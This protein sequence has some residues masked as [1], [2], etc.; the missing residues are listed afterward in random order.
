MKQTPEQ[1]QSKLLGALDHDYEVQDIPTVLEVVS[2]LEKTSI[3]RDDL[4]RTRM[5][6]HINKLRRQSQKNHKELSKRLKLLVKEWQ[7]LLQP[8]AV[9][10]G[11]SK[12]PTSPA[13][14]PTSRSNNSTPTSNGITKP[15]P[16]L[17]ISISRKR[18]AD[19]ESNDVP[20]KKVLLSNSTSQPPSPADTT[21][22]GGTSTAVKTSSVNGVPNRRTVQ[23]TAELVAGIRNLSASNSTV[24]RIRNN[25]IEKE[26]DEN[27]SI[28]P[29]GARPRPRKPPRNAHYTPPPATTQAVLAEKQ[30]MIAEYVQSSPSRPPSGFSDSIRDET[31][32]HSPQEEDESTPSPKEGEVRVP[33]PEPIDPFSLLPPV[34]F[35]VLDDN[36]GCDDT[37][38][39]TELENDRGQFDYRGE[40]RNWTQ[41]VSVKSNEDKLLHLFPYVDI[42]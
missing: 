18:P 23:S 32:V 19:Q 6:F 2:I 41:I 39:I 31:P 20:N 11:I 29:P 16:K 42:D 36:V 14:Q 33:S 38:P 22:S 21:S 17:T 27:I 24:K 3:T 1:L 12:K 4:E 7:K 13:V 40:W 34:D 10:N 28:V 15:I 8:S 35:S 25:C 37:L 9:A 30:R 5:G 26:R